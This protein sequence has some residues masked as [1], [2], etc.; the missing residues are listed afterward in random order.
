MS[1]EL[2]DSG[3]SDYHIAEIADDLVDW[4]LL[5]PH[6]GLTESEQK[7]ITKDYRGRYKLQKLQALRVWRWKSGDKATYKNLSGICRSQGLVSLAERIEGYPGSKQQLRNSQILHTFQRYLIDCYFSSPHPATL[8]W[9]ETNSSLSLHAPS[10]FLDLILREAPL[11]EVQYC[12][13]T[14]LSHDNFKT[15]TLTSLLVEG[16]RS[17]R[18]LVYFKGIGGSG[19]TT[20][21]WHACREW[22]ENRLLNHFQLVIHV[23]LSNPNVKSATTLMDII[24]YPDKN[25]RQAVA[26]AIVDQK[27]K[28]VCLLLDGLD[29][30]PTE[31]LDFLLV[32]LLQGRLGSVQLPELSFVM[33]SRPDWRVTR[34]LNSVLSS[35]ILLAGFNRESLNKYLDDSLG[36]DSEEKKKLQEEFRI[37]PR[38]EG[39]CC[40]PVNAAIM[41]YMIH[42]INTIPTTQTTLHDS[43]IKNFLVRHTDSRLEDEE[44]C[45]IHNLLHD[46]C[47]PQEICEPFRRMCLLAHTSVLEKKRLFTVKDLGQADIQDTLGLLN[48]RATI[49][50]FGSKQYLSFYHISVQEFLAAVHLSIMKER[51]QIS[52]IK[53]FLGNNLVQSQ[54]LSFYAGLTNFSNAK[55]FKTISEALS[56]AVEISGIVEQMLTARTDP[57]QKAIAFLKCLYE[58]QNES[59]I[60]LPE[61]DLSLNISC[62]QSMVELLRTVNVPQFEDSFI[63]KTLTLHGLT[64][65]PLDCLSLGYYIRN[66]VTRRERLIFDL[67]DCSVREIGMRLLLTEMTKGITEC[68]QAKVHLVLHYNQFDKESLFSLKDLLQ[69]QLNVEFLGLGSCFDSAVID[70]HYALKCLIEGLANNYSCN[71]IDLSANH[72]DASHIYH[73]ILFLRCCSQIEYLEFKYYDL[74]KVISLF[75]SAVALSSL[76]SLNISYCNI[77][78][79]DLKILGKKLH[80]NHNLCILVMS[81]NKFTLAGLCKFLQ[82]FKNNPYSQLVGLDVD[83]KF[84]EHDSVKQIL[85]EI[86]E[87]RSKLPYQCH[88]LRTFTFMNNELEKELFSRQLLEQLQTRQQ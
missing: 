86:N 79:S 87:F 75:S 37:N 18:M 52:E 19:K 27:G 21:S 70:S 34:R 12:M 69:G 8:Q 32:D 40:H 60:K 78:N 7:E 62:A 41:C 80:S 10:T 76:L 36:A 38:I 48:T 11:M 1:S 67:T 88:Y 61:T 83:L 54:V 44:P 66:M 73:I 39:L 9:P 4:E 77:S 72:F 14:E 26:T 47:V 57:R 43:L 82:L 55:A 59:L 85:K 64:L 63:D 84:R 6:L 58:C 13:D 71:S 29:E 65:T 16:E 45:A 25:L 46:S 2:L 20:L 24:P 35:C 15:V 50:M 51:E 22:A 74:S 31:L 28:G 3:V 42:F 17:Q 68:T 5:A 53:K 49:T 33:T 56:Q 30:A 81:D 23:Q